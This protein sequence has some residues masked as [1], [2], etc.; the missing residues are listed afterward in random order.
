M[1]DENTALDSRRDQGEDYNY[2][3]F[4]G[5]GDFAGFMG[6]PHVGEKAPDCVLT[7][8]DGEQVALSSLWRQGHLVVEFGSYT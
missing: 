8:L 6:R 2:A 1:A 3:I 7:A 4:T 5:Q